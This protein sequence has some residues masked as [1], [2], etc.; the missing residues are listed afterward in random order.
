MPGWLSAL[1]FFGS[2]FD[3]CLNE[4]ANAVALA[5]EETDETEA[6]VEAGALTAAEAEY[7][8]ID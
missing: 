6:R 2:G 7:I 5:S 4:R 3:A 8:L 1:E